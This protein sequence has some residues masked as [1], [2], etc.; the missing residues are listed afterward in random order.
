MIR[1]S[2]K[3]ITNKMNSLIAS[4]SQSGQYTIKKIAKTLDFSRITVENA[5]KKQEM[6]IQFVSAREK[7]KEPTV[8]KMRFS[9]RLSRQSSI[10]F[11]VT[12]PSSKNSYR[13]LLLSNIKQRFLNP[14]FP[15]S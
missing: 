3:T 11:R 9:Q 15:G 12:T 7:R 13:V 10:K 14:Q 8:I 6:G 5:I 2:R 1:K 4:M